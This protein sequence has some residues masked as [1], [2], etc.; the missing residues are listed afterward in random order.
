MTISSLAELELEA[1]RRRAGGNGRRLQVLVLEDDEADRL[2]LIRLL[3]RAGL[4]AEV[5]E[6][7]DMEAFR[8]RIRQQPFD[9]VFIDF[10][11]EFENG[12]DALHML[13]AEPA[14]DRAMPIMLSRATDPDVIVEAMRAGCVDYIVKDVLDV[15]A[16]RSCIAAAFERRV[17]FGAMRETQE[18][19]RAI[20][21]LVERLGKGQVPGLA[22]PSG[23][24]APASAPTG[25][26]S[27]SASKRLSS[28]L[29]AD[30]EL[31]WQLR[32]DQPGS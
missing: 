31:L 4:D 21:R 13:L 25:G 28:G 20:R 22:E 15:E 32:R 12:I 3:A 17:L 16:V 2:R 24:F 5:T 11:L 30:L 14:Q 18:L 27:A 7:A 19:R 6:A 1:A 10:W 26:L 29:L 8:Q 9:I 23:R